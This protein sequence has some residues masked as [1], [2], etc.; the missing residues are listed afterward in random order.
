MNGNDAWRFLA[1]RVTNGNEKILV[2]VNYSDAKSG[3]SVVV[4]DASSGQLTIVELMSNQSYSRSGDE[5][6]SSGLG[7]VIDA[8]NAQVFKY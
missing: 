2:V 3:A 5:M 1:W 8:W 7:V 4:S 6:R